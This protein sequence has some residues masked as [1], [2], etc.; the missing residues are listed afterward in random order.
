MGFSGSLVVVFGSFMVALSFAQ[1]SLL[2]QRIGRM[3][4]LVGRILPPKGGA[5]IYMV[6]LWLKK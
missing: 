2:P 1:Y 5:K 4:A 3:V 6:A